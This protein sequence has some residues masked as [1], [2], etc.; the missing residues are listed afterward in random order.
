MSR[1]IV[2]LVSL[3]VIAAHRAA[4]GAEITL[5]HDLDSE[6]SAILAVLAAQFNRGAKGGR[7]V[8]EKAGMARTGRDPA[9]ILALV[10]DDDDMSI[11]A[12]RRILPLDRFM[13][14]NGRRLDARGFFPALREVADGGGRLRALPLAYFLP[15]LYY[16][17]DALRRA[18]VQPAAPATWFA[19]QEAAGALHEAGVACPYTSSWPVW[20]HLENTSAQHHEPFVAVGTGALRLAF[21]SLVNVKHVAVLASWFKSGYFRLFGD[22]AEADARFIAGECALLTSGSD[23]HARIRREAAFELGVAPLPYHDDV[24]GVTPAS[25]APG[26]GSLW[27]LAGGRRAEQRL[28]ASFVAFLLGPEVQRRWVA[29]SGFL[30]LGPAAGVT[31]VAGLGVPPAALLALRLAERRRLADERLRDGAAYRAMRRIVGEEL[32]A[33]WAEGKPAKAA[34]DAAVERGNAALAAKR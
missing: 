22:A 11:V 27:V 18:G 32:S 21:N 23:A 25:V 15:V 8:V 1:R 33:V 19:L 14:R 5:L 3:F 29:E 20:V 2:V 26:G 31:D 13:A 12:G 30:P 10:R 7:V 9:P 24:P 28:A 16:N 17:K 6:R 4:A 34:L